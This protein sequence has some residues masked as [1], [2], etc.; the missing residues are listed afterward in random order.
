MG[1]TNES[2]TETSTKELV[3]RA[4]QGN[5]SAV[6]E[7]YSRHLPRALAAARIRLGLKLREHLDSSDI[8]QGAC[9]NSLAKL[10]KF[11]FTTEGAFNKHLATEIER[12]IVD[13]ARKRER[14]K[15]QPTQPAKHASAA[16]EDTRL[17]TPSQIIMQRG[18]IQRL[19]NAIDQLSEPCRELI[20]A[21]KIEEVSWDELAEEMGKSPDAVR[22]QAQRCMEKLVGVYD[23]L[24]RNRTEDHAK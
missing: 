16:I 9:L 10:S 23:R 2:T 11:R 14:Q 3:S 4:Q 12:E 1:R 17:S 18:N 20:V 21:S 6:N 8:V 7:L 22:M 19:W 5:Q 15:R 13:Q 24:K